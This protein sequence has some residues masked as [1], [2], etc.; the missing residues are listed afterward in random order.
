MRL[1]MRIES[2]NKEFPQILPT[3]KLELIE[4]RFQWH[5]FFLRCVILTLGYVVSIAF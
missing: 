3:K 2:G 1:L 4:N 5:V